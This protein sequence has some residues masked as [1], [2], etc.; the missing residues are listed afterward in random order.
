MLKYVETQKTY[1]SDTKEGGIKELTPVR[2]SDPSLTI[3]TVIDTETGE[4]VEFARR[5]PTEWLKLKTQVICSNCRHIEGM[6]KYKEYRFCPY[7]GAYIRRA[8]A[9]R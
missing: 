1:D 6:Y 7:C 3:I 8:E 5:V 4:K 9:K 2:V